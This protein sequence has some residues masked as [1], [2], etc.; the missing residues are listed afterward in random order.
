MAVNKEKVTEYYDKNIKQNAYK[1]KFLTPREYK[2]L[3]YRYGIDKEF[4]GLEV[5]TLKDTGIE[6]GISSS[7]VQQILQKAEMK[8]KKHRGY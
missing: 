6:F 1:L 3:S 5:R 2:M 8:L 4:G 7:R